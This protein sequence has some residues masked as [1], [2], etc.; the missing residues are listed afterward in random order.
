MPAER[1]AHLAAGSRGFETV[2]VV[3]ATA[4]VVV[5]VVGVVVG[6]S[7]VLVAPDWR[8]LVARPAGGLSEV[9]AAGGRTGPRAV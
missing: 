7:L 8:R 4:G 3:A 9:P 1:L 6:A 2:V 5:V